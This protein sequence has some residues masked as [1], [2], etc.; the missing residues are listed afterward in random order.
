MG[1]AGYKAAHDSAVAADRSSRGRVRLKGKDRLTYLQGV[2]TNDVAGLVAGSGC[3]AA[4]L[5]PQGRMISDMR[6]HELGDATLLDLPGE[7]VERVATQLD[8]FVFSE[9]VVVE[10]VRRELSHFII[11]GPDSGKSLAVPPLRP[12]ENRRVRLG[13][14]DVIASGNDDCGVA[15][16]DVFF[17]IEA[18]STVLSTLVRTGV[19]EVDGEVLETLRIEAGVPRFGV[20]MDQDTIPL[21]AGIED[22]AISLTK[23]CY[24]GQEVII[25]VL[26]RGHGRVAR[27]L[28]GFT[29]PEGTQIPPRGEGVRSDDRQVGS[30]TSS[31]WSPALARPIA[32]G[33]VHRDFVEPGTAVEIAAQPAT[34]VA[35][36]FTVP[37]AR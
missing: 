28:V 5:T 1:Q 18:K 16:I 20:D 27:R 33:Y 9:D 29:L 26:H 15:A 2:L 6:V 11:I 34:V 7:L 35:L 3:Y 21:E 36:P 25:R 13:D 30:I 23:G 17:P 22:R 32:L 37:E 10:D 14:T 19:I 12:F 24:V 4:L 31:T 8:N